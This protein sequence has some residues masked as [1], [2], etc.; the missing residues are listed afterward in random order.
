[1]AIVSDEYGSV[2][3]LV[4]IEDLVEEIVGDIQDE[5]D[6]EEALFERVREN[7]Y[8]IDAKLPVEEFDELVGREL[9]EGDY[10]TLGGFVI[11]QLDKIP[12]TGDVVHFE[13]LT[14]TVLGTKGRR[15]TKVRVVRQAPEAAQTT[16]NGQ[17][18]RQ[19]ASA[20]RSGEEEGEQSLDSAPLNIAEQRA[21]RPDVTSP[22]S[23]DVPARDG[24]ENGVAGRRPADP[25]APLDLTSI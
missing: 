3:G 17:E 25:G 1:M 16:G 21:L 2:V 12:S 15:V 22:A 19:E 20:G 5:Y 13:D 6:V 10:E 14:I 9:P 11:A 23:A 18:A 4:T 24:S 7:E 8:I